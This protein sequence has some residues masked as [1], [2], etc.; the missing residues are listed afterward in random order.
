MSV[1]SGRRGPSDGEQNG[2]PNGMST[3]I[4]TE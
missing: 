2:D 1:I 3:E 4:Q